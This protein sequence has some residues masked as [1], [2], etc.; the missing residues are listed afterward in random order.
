MQKWG[1]DMKNVGA[2]WKEVDRN[3]KG[4]VLF[5]EFCAWAICHNLDLDDDDDADAAVS[6][7]SGA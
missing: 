1:L 3:G 2:R 4:K 5:D 7:A 6:Q